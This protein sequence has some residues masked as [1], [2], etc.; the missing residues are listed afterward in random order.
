MYNKLWFDHRDVGAPRPS[1]NVDV[2]RS[3]CSLDTP[4]ELKAV[5]DAL[6]KAFGGV[7]L[8]KNGFAD[9]DA[10]ESSHYRAVYAIVEFGATGANGGPLTYGEMAHAQEKAWQD[11]RDMKD[12]LEHAS[13]DRAISWMRDGPL[14][15]A[16]VRMYC[17]VQLL[18]E[19]YRKVRDAMHLF[20]N[21]K[22][23]ATT[24]ALWR[25]MAGR[26]QPKDFAYKSG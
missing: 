24:G 5:Y 23:C 6:D 13:I 15:A 21:V 10:S 12:R 18:L 17:E 20:Y 4:G 26:V 2:V 25:Q 9:A 14:K 3:F 7:K 8:C 11:F 16:P 22:R 19:D 1:K